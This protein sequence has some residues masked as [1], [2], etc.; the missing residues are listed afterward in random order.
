[1]SEVFDDEKHTALDGYMVNSQ[2]DM[3]DNRMQRQAI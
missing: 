1:M 3:Q 2:A